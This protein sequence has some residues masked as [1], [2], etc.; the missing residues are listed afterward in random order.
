M[1]RLPREW[2]TPGLKSRIKHFFYAEEVPYGLALVRI[3]L[4]VGLLV[5]LVP[6]WQYVREIYSTDGVPSPLWTGYGWGDLFPLVSGTV[7]IVMFST[8]LFFLITTML[9]WWTR[10]SLIAATILY[11]YINLSD[12]LSTMTKYSVIACHALMLLSLSHCGA[13]WSIDSWLANRSR[14]KLSWPGEP[15]VSRPQFAVWPRRL[16]Q[17]MIAFVYFGAAFTKMH[18]QTFLS[19]EQL[20]TWMN[21][22]V[23]FAHPLGDYMSLFPVIPVLF[24]YIVVIWEVVFIFLAW[25]GF[26]RAVMIGLGTAFHLA[27][28][29]VL[30]LYV[31][32]MICISIYFS[33]L[34]EDD[35]RRLSRFARKIS[36]K[37]HLARFDVRPQIVR[38]TAR[39]RIPQSLRFRSQWV[40]GFAIAAVGLGGLELEYQLDRYGD[41]RPEGP[42]KL[43]QMDSDVVQ[44]MLSDKTPLRTEDKFLFFDIGKWVVGGVLVDSRTEFRQGDQVIAQCTLNPP[45]EDMWI[46]CNLHDAQGRQLNRFGKTV[47]REELRCNFPYS[48]PRALEPGEYQLVLKTR[49]KEIARRRFTL[50]PG[51]KS[52]VAN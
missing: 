13:V 25:R 26:S 47:T 30:G 14:A 32:P 39:V 19:G 27:T 23:N 10:T 11:T 21:T 1:A 41:R 49:G 45:H 50:K 38:L 31:F 16:M 52:P 12:G 24:G 15:R 3:L 36:R 43:V 44:K 5:A 20:Q 34:E 18:T 37:W 28:T 35:V 51:P 33:F 6:R 9:G 7:A 29:F 48:F 17:L 4:P 40:Y 46:E 42:Y 8:L 2:E 22:R